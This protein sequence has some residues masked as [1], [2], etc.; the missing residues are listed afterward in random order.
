M[1][2]Q[3]DKNFLCIFIAELK[4]IFRNIEITSDTWLDCSCGLSGTYGWHDAFENAC[5]KTNKYEL[6]TYYDNLGWEE[7]DNFDYQMSKL[8]EKYK[9][10]S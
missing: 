2:K 8:I 9:I 10:L 5:N 6:Y 3:I 7:S 4:L 1:I